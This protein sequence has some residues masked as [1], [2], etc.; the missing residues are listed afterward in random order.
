VH[1][2]G[3]V[4]EVSF[5]VDDCR[6]QQKYQQ[7]AAIF[8]RKNKSAS[9]SAAGAAHAILVSE[10]SRPKSNPTKSERDRCRMPVLV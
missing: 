2:P 7:N 3:Q 4:F 5:I 10:S 8:A 6:Y 1:R 9:P